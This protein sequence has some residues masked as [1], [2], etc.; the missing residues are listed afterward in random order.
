MSQNFQHWPFTFRGDVGIG[1]PEPPIVDEPV[2]DAAAFSGA[3]QILNDP[4]GLGTLL[5]AATAAATRSP[6]A[7]DSASVFRARYRRAKILIVDERTSAVDAVAEQRVFDRIRSLAATTGQTIFLITH[8][9]REV[10]HADLI[11]VLKDGRVAESGT[12]TELMDDKAAT[13]D[14]RNIQA[15][16]FDGTCHPKPPAK[17][18]DSGRRSR[19]RAAEGRGAILNLRAG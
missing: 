19:S 6:A 2:K 1:R 4:L 11:H 9:L 3:D 17:T 16:A 15:A 14:F 13:G 8:R 10:R 18:S 12:F 7:S 5:A